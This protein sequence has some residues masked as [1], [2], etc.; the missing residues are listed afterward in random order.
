MNMHKTLLSILILF[1]PA[2]FYSCQ[3]EINFGQENY[4]PKIVMNGI[5]SPEVPIE[6]KI[7]KSFLFTDTSPKRSLLNNALVTLSINGKEIETMRQVGIEE[8]TGYDIYEFKY[9]SFA[10]IFRSSAKAAVGD[11]IRIT[12]SAEGFETVWA[13]T[14]IPEAP[15]ISKVDTATFFTSKKIISRNSYEDYPYYYMTEALSKKVNMEKYFRNMRIK[16]NMNKKNLNEKQNFYLQLKS[17]KEEIQLKAEKQDHYFYIY[18]NDDPIFEEN[19]KNNILEDL[20]ENGTDI[21]GIRYFRHALFSDKLF[22]SDGYTLNFAITDYY[23]V[24]FFRESGE[25]MPEAE[26]SGSPSRPIVKVYNPPVEV[27]LTTISQELYPYF[28]SKDQNLDDEVIIERMISEPQITFSNV[29]NGI[30]IVGAISTTS[31][32]INI[33]PFPGGEGVMPRLIN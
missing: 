7:S 5:I 24:K 2:L 10:S 13:E 30:G 17:K 29:H 16:I 9:T 19:N 26:L 1:A 25:I 20:I 8:Y 21:E 3:Q 18:T 32:Q 33:I 12:A 23:T 31:T 6:I 27:L 15:T 11:H 22:K 14:T 4:I 28:K